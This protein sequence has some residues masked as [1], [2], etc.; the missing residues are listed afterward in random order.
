[1]NLNEKLEKVEKDLK[2]NEEDRKKLLEKK[3][4]ITVEIDAENNK[5]K[6]EKNQD[7]ADVVE[8]VFGEV[9]KENMKIFEDIMIEHSDIFHQHHVDE[10]EGN[11]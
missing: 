11:E 5:K 8:A 1:M 3:K 2:K 7:I 10:Y 4:K 9:T 6:I